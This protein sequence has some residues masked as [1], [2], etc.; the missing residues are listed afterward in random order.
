MS[1][2]Q[3]QSPTCLILD[4]FCH[5]KLSEDDATVLAGY[6]GCCCAWWCETHSGTCCR[7]MMKEC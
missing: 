6:Q 7:T 4:I 3:Q 2:I 1:M 5:S